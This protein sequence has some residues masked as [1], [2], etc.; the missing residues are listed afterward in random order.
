MT[1]RP[2]LTLVFAPWLLVCASCQMNSEVDVS[3][4]KAV[5]EEV[6][7]NSIGWAKAKDTDLLVAVRRGRLVLLLSR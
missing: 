6:I 2:L 7:K 4:E 5:I 1:I 3:A